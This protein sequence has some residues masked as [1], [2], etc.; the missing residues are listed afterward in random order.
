VDGSGTVYVADSEKNRVVSLS[1]GSTSPTVLPLTGLNGPQGV[2]VDSQGA[3]YVADTDNNRV[4]ELTP[5]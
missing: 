2:A 5:R 3:V 4:V 1:A